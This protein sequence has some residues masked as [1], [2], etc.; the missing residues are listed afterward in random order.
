VTYASLGQLRTSLRLADQV[1]DVLLSLALAAAAEAIDAYCGRTFTTATTD[2]VRYYAAAK[3]DYVEVDD[4]QS[5]TQVATSRDGA[6]WDATTD[7]QAEPLNQWTDGM[8]WPITRLR[9]V[10][11]FS[12]PTLS[13]IQTV[14]VTGKF[15]FGSTPSSIV[16][17]HIL[18]SSRIFA[19]LASPLGV[20]GFDAI[21]AV[22]VRAGLDVDVQ[23]LLSPYR[24]YRAAL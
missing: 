15:G 22:T 21:G 3:F 18:Q 11:N 23:Q 12:W 5:I 2:T 16:Q 24:K 4:L 9:T 14:K 1:D 17:A 19:R 20:A 13:G 6:S 7:Y 8:T 10:N